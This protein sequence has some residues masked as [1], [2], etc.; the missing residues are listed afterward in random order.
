MATPT[1]DQLSYIPTIQDNGYTWYVLKLSLNGT[2]TSLSI[3]EF[4]ILS[5]NINNETIDC[6]TEKCACCYNWYSWFPP[7]KQLI[8]YPVIRGDIS[9]LLKGCLKDPGILVPIT[10]VNLT[11]LLKDEPIYIP[12]KVLFIFELIDL[13]LT[14]YPPVDSKIES[15]L[16]S[17]LNVGLKKLCF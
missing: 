16:E 5:K 8:F 9:Q 4:E 12:T 7:R 2:L 13:Q 15:N 6:N 14:M 10:S 1:Y 17:V 3:Q 11:K